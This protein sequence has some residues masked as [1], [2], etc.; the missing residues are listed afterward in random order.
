M[1][2]AADIVSYAVALRKKDVG[3]CSVG[4]SRSA[5]LFASVS[6]YRPSRWGR[7][8]LGLFSLG[9]AHGDSFEPV[10]C[11]S[12][13]DGID[14]YRVMRLLHCARFVQS[15]RLLYVYIYDLR[16]F[17]ER[18]SRRGL[19]SRILLSAL[20]FSD[21]VDL[22][23]SVEIS[24]DSGKEDSG[25]AEETRRGVEGLFVVDGERVRAGDVFR[26]PSRWFVDLSLGC[27]GGYIFLGVFGV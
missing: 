6:I 7:L 8:S 24:C 15:F 23:R 1:V 12:G 10:L 22:L 21:L 20:R 5:G 17:V 9:R 13:V 3:V 18:I 19:A 4:Y 14:L 2:V 11:V 26:C 25:G 27:G 16:R